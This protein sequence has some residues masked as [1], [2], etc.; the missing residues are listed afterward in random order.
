MPHGPKFD[1]FQRLAKVSAVLSDADTKELKW[2]LRADR[3]GMYVPDGSSFGAQI[4][5]AAMFKVGSKPCKVC[6]GKKRPERPGTGFAP[7]DGERYIV[8]LRK[9]RKAE[10]KRL[11]VTLTTTERQAASLRLC[12]IDA[13]PRKTW[14][15][16]YDQLP[17]LLC[18]ECVAC[19]GR[20]WIVRVSTRRTRPVTARPTGSSKHGSVPSTQ[21]DEESL[22]RAAKVSRRL[23]LVGEK[24]KR[25]AAAL[26]RWFSPSGGS[27]GALWVLVPCGKTMLKRNHLKLPDEQFFSNLR[28][29]LAL[30]IGTQDKD[31]QSRNAKLRKLIEGATEQADELF[32]E[33][34][35][36]WNEVGQ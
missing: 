35:R 11:K 8:A 29:T 14:A 12:G 32:E 19:Q 10:A 15:L 21:M 20:G 3:D 7:R 26:V 17:P 4:E 1:A 30:T 25:A 9:F 6:G 34:C 13:Y 18:A 2:Y 22:S 33:A 23:G 16:F 27:S 5:R 31:Q 24:D 28:D 36:L